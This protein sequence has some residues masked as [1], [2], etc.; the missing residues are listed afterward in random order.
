[1]NDRD[2]ITSFLIGVIGAPAFG[3][4]VGA[5]WRTILL[6]LLVGGPLGYL[7]GRRAHYFR[8]TRKQSPPA[9]D[10][11]PP[12]PQIS[13]GRRIALVSF[14]VVGALVGAIAALMLS[15]K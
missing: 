1:M 14:I 8:A 2:A 3:L 6:L 15:G 7:V 5:E 4:L 11:S 9:D 10:S 13:A 12:S